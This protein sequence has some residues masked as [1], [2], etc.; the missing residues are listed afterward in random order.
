MS[1]HP[2]NKLSTEVFTPQPQANLFGRWRL[3]AAIATGLLGLIIGIVIVTT[4]LQ[5]NLRKEAEIRVQIEATA[6]AERLN[7]LI[8][9]VRFYSANLPDTELNTQLQYL[10]NARSQTGAT[11]VSILDQNADVQSTL[12]RLPV[13]M[14]ISAIIGS[15]DTP[16]KGPTVI[17]GRQTNFIA[18]ASDMGLANKRIVWLYPQS[19]V[20]ES[21]DITTSS[22]TPTFGAFVTT[23]GFLIGHQINPDIGLSPLFFDLGDYP[24]TLQTLPENEV[25][26][27]DLPGG[28]DLNI[29]HFW[30]ET[31]IAVSRVGETDIIATTGVEIA[32]W[33]SWP[34]AII[35]LLALLFPTLGL[36]ALFAFMVAN[37]WRKVDATGRDQLA[38]LGRYIE[39]NKLAGIGVLEW[40][41]E[42]ME[43][44]YSESWKSILGYDE[45]GSSLPAAFWFDRIHPDDKDTALANLEKIRSGDIEKLE[46]SYRLMDNAKCYISIVERA[47]KRQDRVGSIIIVHKEVKDAE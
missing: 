46:Q 28:L 1:E 34:S 35:L 16:I 17:E 32:P 22:R 3:L 23:D 24:S 30:R 21:I 15:A 37:E 38:R 14:D 41:P 31:I 8:R 45:V 29:S 5:N 12:G 4:I 36:M 20:S 13:D 33:Y 27:F 2:Y 10:E 44:I 26:V 47:E 25:R 11:L 19:R 43:A 18:I 9:A 39:A 42:N 6:L 40:L 7:D